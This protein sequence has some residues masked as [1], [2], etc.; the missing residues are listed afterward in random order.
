MFLLLLFAKDQ[1]I[2]FKV[3]NHDNLMSVS[4]RPYDAEAQN[5]IPKNA[6]PNFFYSHSCL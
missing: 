4:R 5:A 6:C 1:S 2:N 3:I